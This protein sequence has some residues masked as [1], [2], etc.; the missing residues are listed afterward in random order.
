MLAARLGRTALAALAVMLMAAGCKSTGPQFNPRAEKAVTGTNA[1]L[2][3][4]AG[5]KQLSPDLLKPS[6]E[7]FRLGPGDR[8]EIEI[9]GDPSS[10][11]VTVVGPDGKIYYSFLNGLDVWGL[12]LGEVKAQIE[13]EMSAFIVSPPPQAGLILRGIESRRVWLLGRLNSAGV[14][15]I[16]SPTTLLESIAMAGG[17]LSTPG[18]MEDLA[19]LQKSFVLRE[20]Q[21]LP[22]DFQGLLQKGD[23]SQNIYLQ[24]DDFVY[25][26]S[27]AAREVHVLGAVRMP[28]SV[29]LRGAPTLVAAVASAGGTIKDAYVSHV[30]IVRG[31]LSNPQIAI[32]DMKDIATGKATDVRLEGSDIVYVPFSPY[33]ALTKYL[34]LITTTFV[35]A[36]AINEG[37]RAVSRNPATVGVSIGLGVQ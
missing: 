28:Q 18:S 24:P 19:D 27:A 9:I 16:A 14:Y 3:A 8:L 30:A 4:A 17:T 20:G 22:V 12:T 35:R 6:T 29:P 13:K 2:S 10:R 26:P 21:M 5:A 25:L 23:M 32:V 36:V 1:L 7:P 37:A 31:S 11:A 15:P 33:R 34:D